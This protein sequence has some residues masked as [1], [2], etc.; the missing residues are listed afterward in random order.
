VLAVVIG[1]KATIA[2]EKDA[3]DFVAGYESDNY[4]IVSVN[5]A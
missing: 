5:S 3:V 1:K 2:N 4:S